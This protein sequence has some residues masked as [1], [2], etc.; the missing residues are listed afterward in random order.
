[1]RLRKFEVRFYWRDAKTKE[2]FKMEHAEEVF[3]FGGMET[4]IRL[5]CLRAPRE[6]LRQMVRPVAYEVRG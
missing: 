5:G 6:V 1:M 4:A 2:L 3:T